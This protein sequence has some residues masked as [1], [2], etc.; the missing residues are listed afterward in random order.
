M[1]VQ[2][3]FSQMSIGSNVSAPLVR[4]PTSSLED[5]SILD[6]GCP[7]QFLAVPTRSNGFGLQQ[8]L[9]TFIVYQSVLVEIHF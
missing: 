6:R 3:S 4:L 9:L 7:T 1:S 5:S 8:A 2:I